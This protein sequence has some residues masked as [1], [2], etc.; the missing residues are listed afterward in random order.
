M[1]AAKPAQAGA[2]LHVPISNAVACIVVSKCEKACDADVLL[3]EL[4]QG[5]AKTEEALEAGEAAPVGQ[6]A[7]AH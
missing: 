6:T 7:G 3:R 4:A 5:H 2:P 1:Q